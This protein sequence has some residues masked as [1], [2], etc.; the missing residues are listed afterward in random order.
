MN[1]DGTSGGIG[2]VGI[3]EHYTPTPGDD[4]QAWHTD[5]IQ[6]KGGDFVLTGNVGVGVLQTGT[7]TIDGNG[8]ATLK[9]PMY[10]ADGKKLDAGELD[11]FKQKLAADAASSSGH[12]AKLIQAAL[13]RLDGTN[14]APSGLPSVF[15]NARFGGISRDVKGG[16][17]ADFGFGVDQAGTVFATPGGELS[18]EM[19]VVPMRP[20]A[21]QPMSAADRAAFAAA[22]RPLALTMTPPNPLWGEL[23]NDATKKK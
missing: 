4:F 23:L 1:V 18:F 12:K 10:A 14:A 7:V 21:P 22:I 17:K 11:V 9:A 15:E 13:D 20:G 16:I 19:H 5:K 6:E 3:P 8:D 2:P